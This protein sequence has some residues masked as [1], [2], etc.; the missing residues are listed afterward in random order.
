M[1][2]KT[3]RTLE[4][5]LVVLGGIIDTFIILW[6]TILIP[7]LI[8]VRDSYPPIFMHP[9]KLVSNGVINILFVMNTP[10]LPICLS[11]Y[12]LI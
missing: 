7:G 4:I 5:V 6:K 2:L 9:P 11:S 3:K 8:Y 10:D 12:F 1:D